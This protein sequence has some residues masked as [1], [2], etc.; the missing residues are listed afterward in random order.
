LL[1][2]ATLDHTFP[3]IL[4]YIL[5]PRVI[6]PMGLLYAIAPLTSNQT[7]QQNK[8]NTHMM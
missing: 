4:T 7:D 8:L 3:F 5:F 2:F 1:E 6:I